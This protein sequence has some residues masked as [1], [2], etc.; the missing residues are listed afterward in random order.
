LLK[1]KVRWALVEIQVGVSYEEGNRESGALFIV[2][3][4][5]AGSTAVRGQLGGWPRDHRVGRAVPLGGRRGA[6]S[7][8]RKA[9][10]AGAE[11]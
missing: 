8:A 2:V 5:A 3:E 4:R 11:V 10:W 1:S 6:K 7:E 9:R